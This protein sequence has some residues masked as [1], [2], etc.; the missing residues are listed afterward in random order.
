MILNTHYL[1]SMV[2]LN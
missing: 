1:K 2:Q